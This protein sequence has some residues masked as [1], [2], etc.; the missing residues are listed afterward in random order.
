M[1]LI[2][3]DG[4][5]ITDVLPIC[6]FDIFFK[7]HTVDRT[8]PLNRLRD[9]LLMNFHHMQ[10]NTPSACYIG[11]VFQSPKIQHEIRLALSAV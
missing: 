2:A 7:V 5:D 8:W 4:R 6:K 10:L 1:R 11:V 3:F 9:G